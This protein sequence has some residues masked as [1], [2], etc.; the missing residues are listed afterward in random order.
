ML[1]ILLFFVSKYNYFIVIVIVHYYYVC[2][3]NVYHEIHARFSLVQDMDLEKVK[4]IEQLNFNV[5]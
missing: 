5:L 2:C 4:F 3:I 1:E